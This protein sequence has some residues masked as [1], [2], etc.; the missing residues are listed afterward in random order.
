MLI[1]SY[2]TK[3]LFLGSDSVCHRRADIAAEQQLAASAT[4]MERHSA[5][6]LSQQF[7]EPS[8]RTVTVSW[9]VEVSP[10]QPALQSVDYKYLFSY[11]TAYC[12]IGRNCVKGGFSA[13]WVIQM[14]AIEEAIFECEDLLLQVGCEFLLQQG[15]LFLAVD[16]LDRF[17]SKAQARIFHAK[18]VQHQAVC[19]LQAFKLQMQALKL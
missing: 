17:L 1:P 19:A 7:L 11:H 4:Y 6:E 14:A 8:M 16:L 9:L 18:Y 12:C 10:L 13:S 2:D 3:P 5:K 15:T